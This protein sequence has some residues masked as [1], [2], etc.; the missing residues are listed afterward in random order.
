M[1]GYN[2]K[3]IKKLTAKGEGGRAEKKELGPELGYLCT[4]NTVH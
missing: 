3:R 1:A 2:S 4:G